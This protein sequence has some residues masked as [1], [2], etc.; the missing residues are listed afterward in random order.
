[1]TIKTLITKCLIIKEISLAAKITDLSLHTSD[2]QNNK[3][4]LSVKF[5]TALMD[6]FFVLALSDS[7]MFDQVHYNYTKRLTKPYYVCLQLT[8]VPFLT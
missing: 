8:R 3:S 2:R 4:L 1:M 7:I 5:F 6:D